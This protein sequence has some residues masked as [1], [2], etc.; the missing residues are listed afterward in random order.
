MSDRTPYTYFVLHIPTGKK[1]YGSKYGKGANPNTFWKEGGYFTSSMKVKKLIEEYGTNSFKAEV[2]KIF[3]TPD[4]ALE[5][6]YKFLKKVNALVKEEWLNE[7]LGGKKFRNVGPASEKALASQRK[8]KQ[9]PEGNAKRSKTLTGR[10]ISDETKQ[11]RLDVHYSRPIQKEEE[12][13]DKI[14]KHATGRGHNVNTKSKLSKIV[15]RT[16]WINN[17]I[18]QK[19][20]DMLDLDSFLKLGWKQGRILEVVTC[21]HCGLTG[22]KHN[23]VRKHFDHCKEKK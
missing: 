5:Y 8:K 6:E 7:N 1:Y 14:R 13:R 21:P 23:L 3:N 12:R 16:R 22:V 18:N 4:E 17:G 19:K 2:R 20:V 11:K 9:S 15:S 10:I